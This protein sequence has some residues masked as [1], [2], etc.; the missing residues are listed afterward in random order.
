MDDRNG[1]T[2]TVHRPRGESNTPPARVGTTDTTFVE[3]RVEPFNGSLQRYLA[4]GFRSVDRQFAWDN[5]D[6]YNRDPDVDIITDDPTTSGGSSSE[7]D[8]ELLN[9]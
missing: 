8:C 4:D 2:V 7:G 5:P 1:V 9:Y 3:Y 6:T